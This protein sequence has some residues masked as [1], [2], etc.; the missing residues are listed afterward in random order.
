MNM[1]VINQKCLDYFKNLLDEEEFEMFIAQMKGE[2]ALKKALRINTLLAKKGKKEIAGDFTK[3]EKIP[4]SENGYFYESQESIGNTKSYKEG[5]VYS[6][7]ASSQIAVELLEPQEKDYILDLCASP[8]SKTTH[9]AANIQNNAA[10]IANEI[11]PDRYVKLRNNLR[12]FG[13]VCHAITALDPKYFAQN[14]P[15]SFDKILVDAPCSGEGMYFKFPAVLQH[16]NIKTV[17]FNAKRQKKILAHAFEALKPGGRL[18]YSTCTLNLEENEKVIAHILKKYFGNAEIVN[19]DM[20]KIGLYAKGGEY[21]AKESMLKMWPHKWNT[22]G[23]F[24]CILT[25]KAATEEKK[26]DVSKAHLTSRQRRQEAH[27]KERINV[28]SGW[29]PCQAKEALS[30]LTMLNKH[31]DAEVSLPEGFAIVKNNGEYFLQHHS[32]YRKF[33]HMP[34]RSAGV[35]ILDAHQKPTSD[36]LRWLKTTS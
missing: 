26:R 23:F 20:K 2:G 9:I 15:N 10:V 17:K 1:N 35:K 12:D 3:L 25:K 32:L 14:Y 27:K 22:G 5:K 28:R 34:I 8:G 4:W 6:Q 33:A 19:I 31:C 13:S 36:A 30:V 16:W 11:A 7:E 29:K 18:V 24:A 21:K